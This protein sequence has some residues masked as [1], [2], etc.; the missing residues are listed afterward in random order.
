MLKDNAWHVVPGL[1]GI[2]I[3]SLLCSTLDDPVVM[4][5]LMPW[6]F[7]ATESQHEGNRWSLC[8]REIC[9][10]N[11]LLGCAADPAWWLSKP[12]AVPRTVACLRAASLITEHQC[13]L[14]V[15][16]GRARS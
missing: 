11:K 4:S 2:S 12:L 6:R 8:A 3:S 5:N 9:F 14:C 1:G 10:K 16:H 15:L 7:F 13:V